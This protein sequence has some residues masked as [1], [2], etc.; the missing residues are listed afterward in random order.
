MHPPEFAG[1]LATAVW[2]SA[3][4]GVVVAVNTAGGRGWAQ[5]C[6]SRVQLPGVE[7]LLSPL[8]PGLHCQ[9]RPGVQR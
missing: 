4:S 1:E 8:L 5:V 2:D 7:R 9:V 6:G 3:D